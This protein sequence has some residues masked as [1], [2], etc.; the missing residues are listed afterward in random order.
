M[1]R[2]IY[3]RC[4]GC[5]GGVGEDHEE[6][7]ALGAHDMAALGL[8]RGADQGGVLGVELV[9]AGTER[10]GQLHRALDVAAQERDGSGGQRHDGLALSSAG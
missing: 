1:A 10:A 5:G 9:V 6:G 4:A 7:I 3:D 8:H 2:W